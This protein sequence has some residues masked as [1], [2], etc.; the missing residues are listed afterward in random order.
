[1]AYAEIKNKQFSSIFIDC[2]KPRIGWASKLFHVARTVQYNH[3]G[4]SRVKLL[5][6]QFISWPHSMFFFYGF[7]SFLILRSRTVAFLSPG[8]A[9]YRTIGEKPPTF[10]PLSRDFKFLRI[11]ASAPP[12]ID[13]KSA[14]F[15]AWFGSRSRVKVTLGCG[16]GYLRLELMIGKPHYNNTCW[17]KQSLPIHSMYNA[18][19][20]KSPSGWRVHW[21]FSEMIGG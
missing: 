7:Y 8:F 5:S 15:S 19:I 20:D 18:Q 17:L 13:T 10:F 14:P 2:K 11:L 21:C 9:A 12:L 4:C 1:M 16:H 3:L 6:C